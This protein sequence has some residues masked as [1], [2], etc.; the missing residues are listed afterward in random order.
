VHQLLSE[1]PAFLLNPKVHR[2]VS[3]S[4]ESVHTLTHCFEI[5][6]KIILSSIYTLV[7]QVASLPFLQILRDSVHISYALPL[8]YS[9]R[10][11]ILRGALIQIHFLPKVG[12]LAVLLTHICKYI[13]SKQSLFQFFLKG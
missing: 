11:L 6:L 3:S 13:L 7:S 5:Q 4:P 8:Y 1:L 12:F 10:H 2:Q 9:P